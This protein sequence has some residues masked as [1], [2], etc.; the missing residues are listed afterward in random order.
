MKITIDNQKENKLLGRT[1]YNLSVEFEGVT[2]SKDDVA[3]EALKT[4]KAKPELMVIKDVISGF[5]G[6]VANSEV[7][8]YENAEV[9]KRVEDLTLHKKIEE[10]LEAKKKAEDE[11]KKAEAEAKAAKEAEAK[12]AKEEP[13]EES[14]ESG[15]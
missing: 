13:A 3:Q 11:K 8:V 1:E 9:L 15:E 5:G 6:L 7:F 4:L 12:A 14:A 2:P 10:K